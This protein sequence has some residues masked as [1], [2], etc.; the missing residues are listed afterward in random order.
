[1]I[2]GTVG[3]SKNE[4]NTKALLPPITNR[5]ELGYFN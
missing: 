3:D 2:S 1:M 4:L 5:R